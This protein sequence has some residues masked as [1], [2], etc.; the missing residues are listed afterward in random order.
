MLVNQRGV[1]AGA[2]G[3]AAILDNAHAA[4]GD[5]VVDAVVQEDD[6]VADVFLQ[7]VAAEGLLALLAGNDSG[8]AFLLEPG[9]EPAQL[10]AHDGFVGEAGEE[11]FETIEHDALG[12]DRIDRVA[13]ADK[14]ALEIEFA[15]L[16]DLTALD[17][18]VVHRELLAAD[19]LGQVKAQRG[20]VVGEFLAGLLEGH[21]HA[22]L[23]ELPGA[24][25]DKFHGQKGLA[26]AGGPADQRGP[27]FGQAAVGDFIQAADAA[28]AF[29]NAAKGWFGLL[30]VLHRFPLPARLP[31]HQGRQL[32][33]SPSGA[34]QSALP[35]NESR[36][37]RVGARSTG[38]LAFEN[39]RL[40]DETRTRSYANLILVVRLVT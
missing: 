36:R 25:H 9:E 12:T 3:R 26:A 18:D 14:Q 27:A 24:A 23:V 22:R 29:R 10:G 13:E 28:R 38:P 5:L 33:A 31:R 37:A 19:E 15:G 6:A 11:R 21:K 30:S 1:F 8:D 4:R 40:S 16:L 39:P 32:N 17:A 34:P 2:V 7:A 35:E 20:D